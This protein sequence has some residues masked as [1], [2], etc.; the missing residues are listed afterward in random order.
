MLYA[1]DLGRRWLL[2]VVEAPEIRIRGP[3]VPRLSDRPS[4]AAMMR[5][6]WLLMALDC[7]SL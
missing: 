4:S 5:S 3:R 1:L 6:C 7:A 2:F